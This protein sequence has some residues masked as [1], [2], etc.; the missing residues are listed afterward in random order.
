MLSGNGRKYK[1]KA[2]SGH[3][4][5][6]GRRLQPGFIGNG[7]ARRG[8]FYSLTLEGFQ[9]CLQGAMQWHQEGAGQF[10]SKTQRFPAFSAAAAAAAGHG[11]KKAKGM[12][13]F[14]CTRNCCNR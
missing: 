5:I 9:G 11:P 4:V 2:L 8:G 6:G 1:S 3:R 13:R 14:N 7:C 12:A 10:I